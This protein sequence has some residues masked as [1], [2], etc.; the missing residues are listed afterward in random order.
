MNYK[1][2][3]LLLT[4]NPGRSTLL[5][6]TLRA[7]SYE[8]VVKEGFEDAVR[9]GFSFEN[10]LE[11]FDLLV[12]DVDPEKINRLNAVRR[13]LAIDRMLLVGVS[14]DCREPYSIQG[15]TGYLYH[16]SSLKKA[17]KELF[18]ATEQIAGK[19]HQKVMIKSPP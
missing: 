7:E 3:I 17:V 6:G 16:P 12:A 13:L 19:N 5:A 14:P 2:R 8:V 18:S 1:K 15:L 10:T 11:Y 9:L 4:E